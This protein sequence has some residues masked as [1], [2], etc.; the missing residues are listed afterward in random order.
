M[1][2][3]TTADELLILGYVICCMGLNVVSFLI[4]AFYKKKISPNAPYLGFLLSLL[5]GGIFVGT[6]LTAEGGVYISIIRTTALL[7]CS[8]S[9]TFSIVGL[10]LSMRT[11]R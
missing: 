1:E 11:T 7:G 10:L 4:S 5:L 6:F 9:S 3:P 8:M 2:L